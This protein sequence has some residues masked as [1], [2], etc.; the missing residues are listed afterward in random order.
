M[1]KSKSV[2]KLSRENLPVKLK[3]KLGYTQFDNYRM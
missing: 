3:T 1:H 2:M